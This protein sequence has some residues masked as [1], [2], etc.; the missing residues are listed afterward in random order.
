MITPIEYTTQSNTQKNMGR[1][2][3]LF[4]T[5]LDNDILCDYLQRNFD[6]IFYQ[7]FASSIEELSI[8]SFND[9]FRADSPIYV[10]FKE[11]DWTPEFSQTS[12][13]DRLF[14][15]TNK[16]TAPIIEINKTNWETGDSG[17]IYWSKN[18]S[19][20]PKYDIEKFERIYNEIIKWIKKNAVGQIKK[21]SVNLYFFKDA[22][23]HQLDS[24][25]F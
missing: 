13:K 21:S 7:S 14:Y 12:T 9:T 20:N 1:Q 22:W 23:T 19:G 24:K 4:T 18:F 15:I 10:Y 16:S 8:N 3:Q 17:R 2:I 25:L 11:L 5:A 6:C